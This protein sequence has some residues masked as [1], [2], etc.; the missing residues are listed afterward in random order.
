MTVITTSP[1]ET[2]DVARKLASFFKGSETIALRGDLGVG[3]TVFTKGIAEFFGISKDVSSPTFTILNEYHNDKADIYHF[4][5]YR[6]TS[7]D[8]LE[9]TGFFDYIGAGI[10]I[11]EW[12]ENIARELPEN[13]ITV[14]ISKTNIENER[15]IIIEGAEFS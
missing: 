8:D 9:S 7:Y 11:I 6:V 12:S 1:K 5:M 15:K 3:K 14:T 4:D 13:T 2:A 10:T